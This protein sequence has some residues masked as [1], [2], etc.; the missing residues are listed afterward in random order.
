MALERKKSEGLRRCMTPR[1]TL[2][3]GREQQETEGSLEEGNEL[4]TIGYH[5]VVTLHHLS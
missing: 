2:E 5:P 3:T 1:G 4:H